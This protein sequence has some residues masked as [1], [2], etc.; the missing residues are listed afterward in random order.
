[1]CAN[2]PNHSSDEITD[3]SSCCGGHKLGHREKE[4]TCIFINRPGRKMQ[5]KSSKYEPLE[6]WRCID[7]FFNWKENS[8][9][10]T[11]K[12]RDPRRHCD[13]NGPRKLKVRNISS[14]TF[15]IFDQLISHNKI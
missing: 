13:S 2:D 12:A 15:E 10:V 8:V 5:G 7:G 14:R 6:E 9:V 1:M 3:H 4:N 11:F